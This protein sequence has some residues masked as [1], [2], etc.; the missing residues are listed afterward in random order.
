[1]LT[2]VSFHSRSRSKSPPDFYV[3]LEPGQNS[4]LPRMAL[5]RQTVLNGAVDNEIHAL[6]CDGAGGLLSCLYCWVSFNGDDPIEILRRLES[7]LKKGE[8]KGCV[9]GVY[10][11]NGGLHPI[12]V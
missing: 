9:R 2:P 1:M 4:N 11:R 6:M 7:A 3:V 5:Q 10:Y 12:P 8:A